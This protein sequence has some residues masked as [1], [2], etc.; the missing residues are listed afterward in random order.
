M[1]QS[2]RQ[3]TAKRSIPQRPQWRR[4]FLEQLEKREVFAP[5]PVLMVIADQR[6][7]FYQEYGDTKLSLEEAGLSVQVAATTTQPSWAHSGSGQGAGNGRVVP[8][9][10]LSSVNASDYSAIVFVGGWGSSMYQYAVNANYYDS[11][12]N[13]D[14][15]TKAIV[16]DLI[17]DFVDQDKYV[18]AICHATTVLAY[19]RVD[20]VSLI[21]GKNVTT[22]Q[23][24]ATA[25]GGPG[26]YLDGV[27]YAYFALAQRTM[28]EWNGGIVADAMSIGETD[29]SWDDVVVDG[30]IITAQDNISARE[31]GHVIAEHLW[32]DDVPPPPVNNAP[33]IA[34]QA[35]SI[36]EIPPLGTTAGVV[37][38]SDADVGQTLSY[39]IVGGNTNAAFAID[40]VTG[41][42][43]VVFPDGID[44]ETTPVF[45]LLVR[46]TDSGDP[47]LFSDA[48]V[49][50]NV[51]FVA[52]PP[53]MN[54]APAIAAQAF[55]LA[56]NSAV[57]TSVGSVVASD[58]DVGQTLS[59]AIVGGN[60][61]GAFM[62]NAATGQL[63]V[64]NA[65]AID[66]ETTPVFNLTVRVS[67]N[68][69][70]A[71]FS[72]A[73]VTV[74]LGNV[75]E[76]PPGPVSH[77]G[78]NVLIQGTAG[79][80][81]I[82]VW[83]NG[84][85]QPMA[86]IGG[87]VYG[88]FNLG[89]GGRVIVFG[90]DGNDYI[91]ATDS[92]TPVTIYGEGGHDVITG[93]H[94][95]DVIDGGNGYDRIYGM[96][97]N[98]QLFAGAN[99]AMLDGGDGNDLL[100]G[101]TADDQLFGRAGNDI[102]IGGNGHDNLEGGAGEDLLIGRATSFDLN[103]LALQAIFA[104]WNLTGAAGNTRQTLTSS[105]LNDGMSDRLIGGD[106]ADWLEVLAG[107]CSYQ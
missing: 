63:S 55:A 6:D 53:P 49:T 25:G 44:F 74:N 23:G 96:A 37:V 70:P 80:D 11:H 106:G 50:V 67:D 36:D 78:P 3:R 7:F 105:I 4:S 10:A 2:K 81:Y 54:N 76:P 92:H 47:A 19:A 48:T 104:D 28:M 86:W 35:F 1:T 32:A 24:G 20:G 5:L 45:E 29:S 90:G 9:L 97:G 17:N 69:D 73:A 27:D 16:N 77:S 62:I 64:A 94:A 84:A 15:A 93:G 38:A 39:A 8:D 46:V 56:E 31:F 107:D 95:D 100:M 61:N 57:G 99:G 18:T 72:D 83:S 82:Y 60:T 12:Y 58:S 71:L 59:Y 14:A 87:Q 65:G 66:F 26:V 98:D 52:P 101:G 68:G 79:T 51:E 43:N 91:Y 41:E 33:V 75:N 102:L 30:K 21:A 13:G 103:L 85:G 34:D 22:P 89:P 88:P 40:S 42:L